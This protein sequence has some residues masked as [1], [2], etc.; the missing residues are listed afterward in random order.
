[1]ISTGFQTNDDPVLFRLKIATVPADVSRVFACVSTF[2]FVFFCLCWGPFAP[3]LSLPGWSDFALSLGDSISGVMAPLLR[4]LFSDA[5]HQRSHISPSLL[6]GPITKADARP[7][8]W[9]H[10][11]PAFVFFVEFL[12]RSGWGF[13]LFRNLR[14]PPFF[15]V[16]LNVSLFNLFFSGFFY[17]GIF[18]P[19]RA[20]SNFGIRAI[21]SFLRLPPAEVDPQVFFDYRSFF[22]FYHAISCN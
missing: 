18:F 11:V 10:F 13:L 3:F 20:L 2:S 4:W 5:W 14:W 8:F 1:M 9:V 7:P 6:Y 16:S 19:D 12:W 21:P 17:P 15:S 22:S